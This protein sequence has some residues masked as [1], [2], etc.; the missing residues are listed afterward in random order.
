M[1]RLLSGEEALIE[2]SNR[3]DSALWDLKR[4][5][6]EARKGFVSWNRIAELAKVSRSTAQNYFREVEAGGSESFM[7]LVDMSEV[8]AELV[9]QIKPF[10]RNFSQ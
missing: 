2:A 6:Y 8:P 5:I 7:V 4:A 9:E 1:T 3:Y 10:A